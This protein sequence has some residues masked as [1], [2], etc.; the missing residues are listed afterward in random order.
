MESSESSAPLLKDCN[1]TI[2]KSHNASRPNQLG[3]LFDDTIFMAFVKRIF[4]SANMLVM[5]V[6]TI[7]SIDSIAAEVSMII[8]TNTHFVNKV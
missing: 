6:N 1:D 5:F 3:E 2:I 7:M 8:P 4:A